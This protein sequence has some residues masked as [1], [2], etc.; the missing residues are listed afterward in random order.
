MF[1]F[2]YKS[3]IWWEKNQANKGRLLKKCMVYSKIMSK[4]NF[5]KN[6]NTKKKKKLI[7]KNIIIFPNQ[8]NLRIFFTNI[9]SMFS[10]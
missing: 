6:N 7:P 9:F 1:L 5:I 10:F 2:L 8:L 3:N 4:S